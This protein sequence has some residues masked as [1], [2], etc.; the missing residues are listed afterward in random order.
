MSCA[1]ATK[2]RKKCGNAGNMKLWGI[3]ID[4]VYLSVE[5]IYNGYIAV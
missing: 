4:F 2:M 5:N 1:T 3:P